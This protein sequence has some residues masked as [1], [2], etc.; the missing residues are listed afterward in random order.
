M[1]FTYI[2]VLDNYSL[3]FYYLLLLSMLLTL[4]DC[5]IHIRM[6]WLVYCACLLCQSAGPLLY[7]TFFELGTYVY[8]YGCVVAYCMGNTK[9]LNGEAFLNAMVYSYHNE[10]L[11]TWLRW[12]WGLLCGGLIANIVLFG[13]QLGPLS[14]TISCLAILGVGVFV[15][16][17]VLLPLK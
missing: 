4:N 14:F 7:V 1:F 12:V 13:L 8:M 15:A 3:S 2:Y 10:E 17:I 16:H 9:V 11:D 5:F 6:Y